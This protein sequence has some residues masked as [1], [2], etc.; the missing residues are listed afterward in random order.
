MLTRPTLPPTIVLVD[1]DVA[2]RTALTFTLELD[3]FMV[4]ALA[5]GEE[6]LAGATPS[7]SD[8]LV[9]DQHLPGLTGIH[10]LEKLRNQG[11][12]SPALLITSHPNL[13]VRGMAADLGAV[14]VEKPL[15]NDALKLAIDRALDRHTAIPPR[16]L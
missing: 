13:A 2:L 15:L 6:L 14:I 8:C 16:P 1:D 7:P 5:S 9:L 4:R 10:T 11:V 12:R 3:G